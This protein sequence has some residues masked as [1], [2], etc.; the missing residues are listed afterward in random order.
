LMFPVDYFQWHTAHALILRSRGDESGAKNHAKQ[1]LEAA[2]LE[3]SR[4]RYHPTVGLVTEKY[5]DVLQALALYCD[6]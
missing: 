6:A 2:S 1:A 3:K 5:S 4:F